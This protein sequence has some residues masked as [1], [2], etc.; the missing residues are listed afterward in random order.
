MLLPIGEYRK[1]EIRQIA[2]DMRLRVAD[3]KDSQEICFVPHGDH[4]A[5]IRSRRGAVDTAGQIVTTD[6]RV[7]GRH[8]GLEQFTIGQRKGLGVALGQPRFVV[9]LEH[10]SRRVVIGTKDELARRQLSANRTNWLVSE[11]AGPLRCH[12]KIRY[13]SRL[14]PAVVEASNGRRLQVT[15]DEPQYGVAPG[16]AVVCYDGERL[17][18]GGWIE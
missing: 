15:L 8:D 18:G 9:R 2:R 10:D 14:A 13:N 11:P 6:G 3:K 12:V 17:L 1:A 16:Q 7:V 5:F 4:A